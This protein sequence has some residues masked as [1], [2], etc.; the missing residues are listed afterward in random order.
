[1]ETKK[2]QKQHDVQLKDGKVITTVT[3]SHTQEIEVPQAINMLYELENGIKK[4]EA[5]IQKVE[6]DIKK[7]VLH[8]HL[9]D[10]KEDLVYLQDAHKKLS[11]VILSEQEKLEAQMKK[12]IKVLKAQKGYDR[13]KEKNARVTMSSLIVSEV[14]NKRDMDASHPLSRKLR[15]EFDSI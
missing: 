6:D 10:L 13:V 12:E 9:S 8:Q 15:V 2:I 5:G 11:E 14:C 1:M 3:T 7:E 4:Q